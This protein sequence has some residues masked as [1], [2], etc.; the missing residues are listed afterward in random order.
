MQAT[1]TG[2]R[3]RV[4]KEIK[5]EIVHAILSGELFLEEAM[6]KYGIRNEISIINWIKEYRSQV[7]SRMRM[8]SDFLD[9]RKVKDETVLVAAIYQKIQE[10]EED[11]RLLREQKAYLVEKI[12]VLEMEISQVA[13]ASTP[14]EHGK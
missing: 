3:N 11:N 13:D 2:K 14:Y 1:N 5:L 9:Q 7:E 12:S 4:H 6:V 8:T 10:L